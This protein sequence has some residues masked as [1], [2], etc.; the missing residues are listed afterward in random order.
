MKISHIVS[1]LFLVGAT[2][3]SSPGPETATYDINTNVLTLDFPE[4]SKI[5]LNN[6]LLGRISITDGFSEHTLTGG[7]L[8]DYREVDTL[9]S[10]QLD[11]IEFQYII[12]STYGVDVVIYDN[13]H[14]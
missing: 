11:S 7:T 4:S 6:I 9:F 10:H 1:S 2:V 13:H 14:Q 8:P 5:S 3:F 12:D